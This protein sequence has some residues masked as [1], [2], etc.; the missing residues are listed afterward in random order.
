VNLAKNSRGQIGRHVRSFGEEAQIE[1]PPGAA[2]TGTVE[3]SARSIEQ[4]Q[5]YWQEMDRR[6]QAE[7]E[8]RIT[9]ARFERASARAAEDQRRA[10]IESQQVPA[11]Y[12]LEEEKLKRYFARNMGMSESER[13]ARSVRADFTINEMIPGN[14]KRPMNIRSDYRQMEI[15][16]NPLTRDGSYGV[17]TDYD[18]FVR[19]TELDNDLVPVPQSSTLLRAK[20]NGNG[21][22]SGPNG[23]PLYRPR[24]S[25]S[26]RRSPRAQMGYDEEDPF[27]ADLEEEESN[28]FERLFESTAEQFQEQAPEAVARAAT[29]TAVAQITGQRPPAPQT[30]YQTGPASY[31]PMQSQVAR[32]AQSSGVPPWA[33]Y[34]VVGLLGV[35]V[36]I[37][38]VKMLK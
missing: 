8:A 16:G 22:F 34:S 31:L 5:Q 26:L 1:I 35:G 6:A 36:L 25:E 3:V 23:E 17:T 9:R 14:P 33:I 32:Y 4:D 20:N 18:R 27:A 38:A 11:T 29:Q 10:L 2:R 30:I 13:T 7:A 37:T 28:W 15:V 24:P 19:G 21:G 12:N